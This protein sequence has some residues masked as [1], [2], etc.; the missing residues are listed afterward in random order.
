MGQPILDGQNLG[1]ILVRSL[2]TS[3]KHPS[4]GLPSSSILVA[5]RRPLRVCAT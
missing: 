4:L 2:T 3:P 5:S 1:W